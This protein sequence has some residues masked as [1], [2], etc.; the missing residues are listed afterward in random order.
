VGVIATPLQSAIGHQAT[1][2]ILSDLLG[3]PVPVNRIQYSQN[4]GDKAIVFKVKGR[5]PEG[6]ILK[7]E[8][9]EAMG[10]EFGILERIE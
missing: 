4:L 1:A 7:R 10:Y 5:V 9:V 3:R 2:E 6:V 8:E